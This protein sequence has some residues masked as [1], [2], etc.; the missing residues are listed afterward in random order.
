MQDRFVAGP[1]RP[2]RSKDEDLLDRHPFVERLCDA[3]I[4]R[5]TT[6]ST[7]VVIGI[8][9]EWGSGK[10]SVL[11]LLH[12][13]IAERYPT[14][15]VVRFDPWLVSGRDDLIRQFFLE[16]QAA[17]K[18][19]PALGGRIAELAERLG[20]YS[21]H[22]SPIID[23]M[24]PGAG[25]ALA[26]GV[27]IAQKALGRE[28]TLHGQREHLMESLQNASTAFVVLV[29]E[30]DRIED[31]EIRATAQLVRAVAD[32]PSIS[33]VLAYD[34]NRVIQALG[35]GADD[36]KRLESGRG[37]L[38]KIVQFQIALPAT[39]EWELTSLLSAEISILT[40]NVGLPR[41]WQESRRFR[42]LIDV[43]IPA[44]IATPRDIKRFVGTY[45]VIASM[46][47]GEVDW[48]DLLAFCALMI[49]APATVA[50]L[51]Q[52]PDLV[53]EN[54]AAPRVFVDRY[55][56]RDS[57]PGERL[58]RFACEEERSTGAPELL[59]FLFPWFSGNR[60]A[61]TRNPDSLCYRR[62]LLTVL[63]LGLLPDTFS[64]EDVRA[65]LASD[66]DQVAQNLWKLH[67]DGRLQAFLERLG[68]VYPRVGSENHPA[69]W[70]GISRFLRRDDCVWPHAYSSMRE[71]SGRFERLFLKVCTTQNDFR[72]EAAAIMR[73]L[74]ND[75]DVEL[76]SA[77][78]RT[79]VSHHGLFGVSRS[80]AT[81]ELLSASETESL[82]SQLAGDFRTRHLSSSWIV[83]LRDPEPLFLMLYVGVWDQ[84]C[85]DR[86][87]RLL[88]E[89]SAFDTFVLQ[90][91][92]GNYMT[93]RDSIA[94][95]IDVEKYQKRLQAR[96]AS[97]SLDS[98]DPTVQRALDRA[99]NRS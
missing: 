71:L 24:L 23:V 52:Q 67:E 28:T 20:T 10:S 86:L 35:T 45:H 46:V 18:E 88:K 83:T 41:N 42:D 49:K 34:V 19:K 7:G 32:F 59:S 92:G 17:I 96:L 62:P 8:T 9:G 4:N 90:L 26:G 75:G 81:T 65:F 60:G 54:S 14:A 29:D 89:D 47:K 37:Y 76:S 73:S 66:I 38:E 87:I 91:F 11:N 39:L 13:H 78:V 51:R 55:A 72:A 16:F 61:E 50:K 63:R 36:E 40:D 80:D 79:Q 30:L 94:T 31:V 85:K 27:A 44:C 48:C 1:E 43:L 21:S 22:L 2:V 70:L 25:G 68:E 74:L 82:A 64:A 57:K 77:I 93:T 15:V 12:E 6:R 84:E 69:V 3:L 58:A 95:L 97:P 5:E 99:A 53:V 98:V 33:Y 56:Q